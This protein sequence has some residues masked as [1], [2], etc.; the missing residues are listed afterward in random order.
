[1]PSD[2]YG[3]TID[4]VAV[5]AHG[6]EAWETRLVTVGALDVAI[7]SHEDGAVVGT[8][9]VDVEGSVAGPRGL[10]VTLNG[11][12]AD[13]A[14]ATFSL[15]DW[16]LMEGEN[17]LTA[18]ALTGTGTADHTITLTRDTTDP[19][20]SIDWPEDGTAVN[21]EPITVTGEVEDATA[22]TVDVN[23]VAAEVYGAIFVA[24]GVE[25]DVG[26]N[27][28]T[29]TATDAAGNVGS[30]SVA[31]TLDTTAPDVDIESHSDQDVEHTLIVHVDGT[32]DPDVVYLTVN[33]IWTEVV[34]GEWE[35]DVYL[36]GEG[37][38]AVTVVAEDAAGNEGTDSVTLIC[39]QPPEIRITEV[40]WS[41]KS[42]DE[43]AKVR[44]L[45]T[46]DDTTATITG[47]NL[48]QDEPVPVTGVNNQ[49]G[50]FMVDGV[51]IFAGLNTLEVIA[52]DDY[53]I[54]GK[55][56]AVIS[57]EGL[58]SLPNG[59]EIDEDIEPPPP[60]QLTVK[61][62]DG[63]Q[64]ACAAMFAAGQIDPQLLVN[65][66]TKASVF[67]GT[68]LKFEIDGVEDYAQWIADQHP[69]K[70]HL[71]SYGV[72]KAF[73]LHTDE[74]E[75]KVFK[76]KGNP[77]PPGAANPFQIGPYYDAYGGYIPM[78][79]EEVVWDCDAFGVGET[80]WPIQAWVTIEVGLTNAP[81]NHTGITWSYEYVWTTGVN[82]LVDEVVEIEPVTDADVAGGILLGKD[83][84]DR[85]V[86]VT[87][88][89]P[90]DEDPNG[91]NLAEVT[92]KAKTYF[93]GDKGLGDEVSWYYNG[94][95]WGQGKTM[96]VTVHAD[97]GD[98]EVIAFGDA[99]NEVDGDTE[100]GEGPIWNSKPDPQ[101]SQVKQKVDTG[102]VTI[103]LESIEDEVT[104]QGPTPL[105]LIGGN[106][107]TATVSFEGFVCSP[108]IKGWGFDWEEGH[109]QDKSPNEVVHV[110]K[111]LS[112]GDDKVEISGTSDGRVRPFAYLSP[113]PGGP[114]NCSHPP[115]GVV[116]AV[117]PLVI[118]GADD[119]RKKKAAGEALTVKPI[120]KEEV[121]AFKNALLNKLMGGQKTADSLRTD[122]YPK[123]MVEDPHI[124]DKKQFEDMRR[125]RACKYAVQLI[126]VEARR[127]VPG[128]VFE[129]VRKGLKQALL[130]VLMSAVPFKS[131]QHLYNIVRDYLNRDVDAHGLGAVPISLNGKSKSEMGYAHLAVL[132]NPLL[133]TQA[134]TR[135]FSGTLTVQMAV[136]PKV[137]TWTGTGGDY[138]RGTVLPVDNGLPDTEKPPHFWRL[139]IPLYGTYRPET[140]SIGTLK[141]GTITKEIPQPDGSTKTFEQKERAER[142]F[143]EPRKAK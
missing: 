69:T 136:F 50:T 109:E 98:K 52:E 23:G 36:P 138:Y 142:I 92:F 114:Q 84:E 122:L 140:N 41:P 15:H 44:I 12:V 80:W 68:D 61:A 62:G 37:Q 17:T 100:G 97:T 30:D 18:R 81:E 73:L 112:G 27:T 66:T 35:T 141:A 119:D 131:I 42:T 79:E 2:G 121:E 106:P 127:A 43:Q 45:G 101:E 19:V 76:R 104:D 10:V 25:L 16:S 65:K 133:D 22:V 63:M 105:I 57:A 128:Y 125:R 28:V 130:D 49:D 115:V 129:L 117:P 78:T 24:D 132:L 134:K 31:V 126:R 51:D 107:A 124:Q 91:K 90:E 58:V 103:E 77:V 32:C 94:K 72:I 47:S 48:T 67:K 1:L 137:V 95:W 71:Y 3:A 34:D 93:Q 39:N 123:Y 139:V 102:I 120:S 21:T 86:I 110:S 54:Q 60:L 20:V 13:L 108:K 99:D 11:E 56:V 9:T 38:C 59:E 118:H 40:V 64:Q 4:V 53:D 75:L 82:V 87:N 8:E 143:L 83:G 46:I 88:S 113:W 26:S 116:G 29:A 135:Y 74:P 70:N 96:T 5:D 89:D 55:D 85:Y 14:A 33:G 7:T 6:N 111:F